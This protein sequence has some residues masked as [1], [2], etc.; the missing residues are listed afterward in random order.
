MSIIWIGC[1]SV[2]STNMCYSCTNV[3]EKDCGDPFNANSMTDADKM[4]MPAGGACMVCL[5]K[6]MFCFNLNK[7]EYLLL[8]VS[9]NEI[10]HIE[11]SNSESLAGIGYSRMS[12]KRKWLQDHWYK[13]RMLLYR[14][15][16][17]WCIEIT[18]T[19]NH[20]LPRYEHT[21]YDHISM[22]LM[23]KYSFFLFNQDIINDFFCC[24]KILF[25]R[26][27]TM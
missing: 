26:C 23:S 9:E 20:C 27:S 3:L 13:H 19:T 4:D 18:T 5:I 17:Q 12:R 16:L 22:V 6:N 21:C 2:A 8:Y 11:S 15:S 25:W 10:W 1:I 24:F 14:G 7:S